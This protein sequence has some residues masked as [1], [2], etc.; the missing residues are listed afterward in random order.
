MALMTFQSCNP[1]SLQLAR[2]TNAPVLYFDLHVRDQVAS[3]SKY[4]LIMRLQ[5]DFVPQARIV[6]FELK[7]G[8]RL[9]SA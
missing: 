8:Q 9:D 1:R 7:H 4:G 6:I 2:P 5:T 3:P